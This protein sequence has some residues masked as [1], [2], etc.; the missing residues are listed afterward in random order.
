[1]RGHALRVVFHWITAL[2]IAAA[3]VIAFG[4]SGIE[5]PDSRLFWLDMHRSIG[6]FI[7]VIGTLRLISRAVLKF[8]Q[9]HESGRL[10]RL[11]AA[12][13]HVALYCGMLALPLLGWAQSSAKMCKFKI[14]DTKLPGLVHHD[15][16]LGE[17]LG[18][19]HEA[20][21]WALLGLIALHVLAA[22][23]HHLVRRDAVLLNMLRFRPTLP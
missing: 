9:L 12:A 23:Y 4:R 11:A 5:D 14:F 19:W 15:S 21:A 2:L 18:Q 3:Y 10:L 16:D 22:V 6:L 20:L 7:L 1:M 13:T 17:R 8:E